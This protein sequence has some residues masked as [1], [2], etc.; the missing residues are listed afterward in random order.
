M[1]LDVEEESVVVPNVIGSNAEAAERVLAERRLVQ[2]VSHEEITGRQPPRTILRQDPPAGERVR[3]GTEV[4][5]VLEAV[6]VLVPDAKRMM[7][8]NA[9]NA[10]QRIGLPAGSIGRQITG[11]NPVGV[12]FY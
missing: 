1:D 2:R 5:L 10:L 9:V 6:S 11:N 3:P 7:E 4:M 12:V 8:G